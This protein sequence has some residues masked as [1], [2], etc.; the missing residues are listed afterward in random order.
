MDLPGGLPGR[1]AV[2]T[3]AAVLHLVDTGY[4]TG[5]V[6]VMDGGRHIA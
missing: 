4:T 3:T 6:L 5:D 2:L 1:G